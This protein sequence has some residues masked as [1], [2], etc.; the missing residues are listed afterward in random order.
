MSAEKHLRREFHVQ[1]IFTEEQLEKTFA[2]VF[3]RNTVQVLHTLA[4]SGHIDHLEFTI[5]TGKEAHVFRAVDKSGN[6]KAVKIYK[7]ETSDFNTMQDYLRH[8]KRF[9]KVKNEKR[10]IVFAWT[11]KEFSSLRKLREGGVNVPMPLIAKD[12]VLVMEFIGKNGEAC[13][14]LKDAR[15]KDLDKFYAGLVENIARMLEAKM[16]HGDLSDYNILVREDEPVIID[17]GQT[18]PTTHPNAKHFYER[19][20]QNMLKVIQRLGRKKLTFEELY[21]DVKEAKLKLENEP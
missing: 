1:K 2:K 7:I 11:Q 4:S 14:K 8:D 9:E 17:C 12:N 6:Y 16:I 10:S 21:A 18:F 20:L 19:D 3:D 13:P 5:S 15:V